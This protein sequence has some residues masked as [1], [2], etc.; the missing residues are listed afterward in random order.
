MKIVSLMNDFGT[1]DFEIGS[2]SGVIL[3]LAPETKLDDLTRV[4]PPQDVLDAS[5]ILSRHFYYF[6]P[7]SIHVVVVDS[8][9]EAD[10]CPLAA[11]RGSHY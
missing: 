4:S 9:V 1:G 2:M 11:R 8:E 6:L 10:T 3:N 5:V 7:G